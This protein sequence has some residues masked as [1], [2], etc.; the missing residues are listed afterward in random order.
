MT[1]ASAGYD[2]ASMRKVRWS[3]VG[4]NILPIRRWNLETYLSSSHFVPQVSH[5][6]MSR[7]PDDKIQWST[8]VWQRI[9]TTFSPHRPE[10]R[11]LHD[12]PRQAGQLYS[13]CVSPFR[14]CDVSS[15]IERRRRRSWEHGSG[16]IFSYFMVDAEKTVDRNFWSMFEASC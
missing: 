6:P 14:E 2:P 3:K 16:K 12:C 7:L 9:N 4:P 10:S 5:F 11:T 8:K 1:T 13:L 15:S